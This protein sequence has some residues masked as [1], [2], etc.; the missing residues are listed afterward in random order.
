MLTCVSRAGINVA[1]MNYFTCKKIRDVLTSDKDTAQKNW[2]GQYKSQATKDWENILRLYDK[3]MPCAHCQHKLNMRGMN[4][5]ILMDT[6]GK[7]VCLGHFRG[8]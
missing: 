6:A 2:L 8:I 3:V 5:S 7:N 1:D 4:A